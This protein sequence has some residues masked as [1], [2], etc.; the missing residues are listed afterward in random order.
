MVP[1][2]CY[3]E[4]QG[5]LALRGSQADV[6]PSFSEALRLH[7]PN[8]LLTSNQHLDLSRHD[9]QLAYRS[10]K[11]LTCVAWPGICSVVA[12]KCT[13]A[14]V[15]YAQHMHS[16]GSVRMQIDAHPLRT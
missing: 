9:F 8:P 13:A 15:Q 5:E 11:C 16:S 3:A 2:V 4:F 7:L 1:L 10:V 14:S 12:A 6:T